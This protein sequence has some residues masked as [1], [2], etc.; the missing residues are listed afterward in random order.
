M[1]SRKYA[2]KAVAIRVAIK[3]DGRRQKCNGQR[4]LVFGS[5]A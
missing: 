4:L 1:V 5:G 2:H 3:A